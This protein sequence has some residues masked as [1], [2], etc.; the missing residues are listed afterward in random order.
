MEV[1]AKCSGGREGGASLSPS[2]TRGKRYLATMLTLR[3]GSLE[4]LVLRGLRWEPTHGSGVADWIRLVTNGAFAL[5]DGTLYPAL[6]RMERH[7]WIRSE[8][9]RSE[10]GRKARF[11]HLTAGGRAELVNR[12]AEWESYVAAMNR[13]IQYGTMRGVRGR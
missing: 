6:H 13:A 4:L 2:H 10:H 5:E 3:P 1:G 8:W 7:G 11:Y 12:I 9:G